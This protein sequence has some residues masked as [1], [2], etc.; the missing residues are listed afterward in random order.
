MENKQ[1]K[2]EI[3]IVLDECTYARVFKEDEMIH[4]KQFEKVR[5]LVDRQIKRTE[6]KKEES[7]FHYRY[8]ETISIFG[9]RGTGKTSFLYS[10][11][12]EYKENKEVEVFPIIDPTLIEEKGHFF[13]LLLSLINDKVTKHLDTKTCTIDTADYCEHKRWKRCLEKLARG[14]PSLDGISGDNTG[15]Q[16]K[17]YIMEQGLDDVSTSFQLE[18]YFHE[19]VQMALQ[20]LGKK[21]FLLAFDDID[22]DFKKGWPVLEVIRKYLTTPSIIT[23]MTGNLKLYAKNVRKQ[24]W[25]R[26]GK[27]LLINEANTP[28]GK[29][30][31]DAL[32]SEIEGQ[33]LLKILKAENRIHLHSVY[34]NYY[35]NGTKIW[36]VVEKN[37][38][39]VLL[40]EL[41]N[42]ILNTYGIKNHNQLEA[43]RAYLMTLSLRT[44]IHF[45]RSHKELLLQKQDKKYRL[46][47]LAQKEQNNNLNDIHCI[48]A[49]LTRMYARNIDVDLVNNMPDKLLGS[50]LKFLLKEKML[51]EAYQLQP[52]L[53]DME[54]NSCLMGLALL[55]S[56]KT[57]KYPWMIFGYWIKIGCPRNIMNFLTYTAEEKQQYYTID[58]LCQYAHMFQNK[59]MRDVFGNVIAYLEAAGNPSKFGCFTLFGLP[60]N[61]N[62]RIT[63]RIDSV[64]ANLP[65]ENKVMGYMPLCVLQFEDPNEQLLYYSPYTLLAAIGELTYVAQLGGDVL[66]ALLTMAQ[67]RSYQVPSEHIN[68]SYLN[69]EYIE[70]WQDETSE[71]AI[72]FNTLLELSNEFTKWYQSAPKSQFILSPHLLGKIFTRFFHAMNNIQ[73]FGLKWSLGHLMHRCII[74]LLNAVLIEELIENYSQEKGKEKEHLDKLNVNNAVQS[75]TIF[76]DNLNFVNKNAAWQDVP[77]LDWLMKCPLLV[78]FLE[79]DFIASDGVF[80]A[81]IMN[82]VSYQY[83]IGFMADMLNWVLRK[84]SSKYKYFFTSDK[85]EN[86]EKTKEI[87]KKREIS[88]RFILTEDIQEVKKELETIFSEASEENIEKFRNYLNEHPDKRW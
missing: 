59:N 25:H 9:N 19:L 47:K 58:R 42:H 2:Q 11:L 18:T 60:K 7:A 28:E 22:V 73:D 55:F 86:F 79:N 84:D 41:Y 21:V 75:D 50:I 70:G 13:L 57:T 29:Q 23:L 76:N 77:L 32:V 34:E 30:V 44:Q 63:N 65:L 71:G 16:D 24:Q 52:T 17:T 31:Y 15:W 33:Y 27:E 5:E 54:V 80:G 45:L 26:F 64:F 78:A 83:R 38:N 72:Q 12:A 4:Q 53:D 68:K 35:S 37:T 6:N 48:E 62:D 88:A 36:M 85:S 43:Y 74:A 61:E 51:A 81:R 3:R 14:I 40:P 67:P 69:E 56:L 82:C 87:L 20:I 10:I 66:G 39:A 1:K 8:H 46:N 49:F